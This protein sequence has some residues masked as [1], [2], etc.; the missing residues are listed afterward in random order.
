MFWFV[1]FLAVANLILIFLGLQMISSVKKDAENKFIQTQEQTQF[2]IVENDRLSMTILRQEEQLSMLEEAVS[3]A[4]KRWSKVKKVRDAVV[5]TI[6]QEGLPRH[7][8]INGLTT[9]AGAVV[10][11]SEQY[12]V[13][14]ALIMAIT[15]QESAFN[16]RAVSKAGAQGL[17]QLMPATARECAND[18]NKPFYNITKVQDNVQF[19]TWYLAK[20]LNIF[21]GDIEL[22]IRAYNAGPV[23]VKRV[24]AGELANYPKETVDY[25]IKVMRYRE[26]YHKLGF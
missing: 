1:C 20:M 7:L 15:T 6:R 4:D 16:P 24:L 10:D 12:D 14:P 11:Y 17:M 25:H 21:N 2:L 13:P 19:G 3:P 22:A 5:T 9:Y 23:Y 26:K 8:D 18:V